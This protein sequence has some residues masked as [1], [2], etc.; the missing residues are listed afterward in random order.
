MSTRLLLPL[1]KRAHDA[2]SSKSAGPA[3]STTEK[4]WRISPSAAQPLAAVENQRVLRDL[5]H[6]RLTVRE[7]EDCYTFEHFAP[8]SG[9]IRSDYYYLYKRIKI[10]LKEETKWS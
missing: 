3:E 2:P 9:L 1:A 7:R 6:S 8:I 4:V 10:C 5:S